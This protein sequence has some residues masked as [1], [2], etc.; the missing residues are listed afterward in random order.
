MALKGYFGTPGSGKTYEVVE[1]VILGALKQGRRVVTNVAGLDYDL[2]VEYLLANNDIAEGRLGTIHKIQLTEDM[3]GKLAII[4]GEG[5][6]ATLSE[7]SIV[8]GGDVVVL[9]EIWRIWEDGKSLHENDKKFLRMHRHLLHPE[10]HVSCDVVLISQS[11]ADVHRQ[12]RRLIEER[13]EMTKHIA[14]GFS[15]RYR[16]NVYSKGARRPHV[17][18][19]K[20]YDPKIFALYKSH[21]MGSASGKE[22]SVD[23]RGNIFRGSFF[24]FLLPGI[25]GLGLLGALMLWKY[26]HPKDKTDTVAKVGQ[27][28]TQPGL[29][30]APGAPGKP[31]AP[32]QLPAV[33]A[34]PAELSFN[35]KLSAARVSGYVSAGGD[36]IVYVDV[37]GRGLMQ[38]VVGPEAVIMGQY[39]QFE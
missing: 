34:K 4:E 18:Y 12:V 6:G 11:Y 3:G 26:F 17:Q 2:M 36:A 1:N 32:G 21:S 8:R 33:P 25:F 14:L 37:G 19:Q 10:T 30:N 29:P 28:A 31:G 24:K 38:I 15:N 27:K 7:V 22:L 9:D 13:Y 16:V 39:V 23:K 20:K 35:E 5:E